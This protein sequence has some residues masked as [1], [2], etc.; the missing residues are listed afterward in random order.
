MVDIHCHILYG[1]DDGAGS[2]EESLEMASVAYEGGTDIIIATPHCNVTGSYKN[3]W[4]SDFDLKIRNINSALKNKDCDLKIYPGQEIFCED[5]VIDLLSSGKLIT[6]NHSRYLLVEFDFYERSSSV[7][8]K[9]D[10]LVSEGYCPVV[11]HPERYAFVNEDERAVFRLKQSGCL[12]Q[13]NKGSLNGSF[14]KH[15]YRT[16]HFILGNS[17]ADI[18]A[19]DAHSPYSRTPYLESA[20]E[21]VAENFS[22]DYAELLFNENPCSVLNDKEVSEF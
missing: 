3:M 4:S 11:A 21:Y 5:N 6:L 12:L 16:S 7:F 20:F 22:F 17:L 14:G 15:A 9:L 10:M 18:I 2:L 8:R 19:S 13:V 1:L